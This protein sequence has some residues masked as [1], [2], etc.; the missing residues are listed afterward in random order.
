M[1]TLKCVYLP[2]EYNNK[3]KLGKAKYLDESLIQ[4]IRKFIVVILKDG[5]QMIFY[6][7]LHVSPH[8]SVNFGEFLDIFTTLSSS[9]IVVVIFGTEDNNCHPKINEVMVM[10]KFSDEQ[11]WFKYFEY[12]ETKAWISKVKQVDKKSM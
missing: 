6:K 8:Y 5:L 12:K 1:E 4:Y 11:Q 9:K 2:K 3:L 7:N 10:S